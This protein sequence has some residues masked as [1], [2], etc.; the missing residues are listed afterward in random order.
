[1][2]GSVSIDGVFWERVN[3]CCDCGT[4]MVNGFFVCYRMVMKI[5]A[6]CYR[7]VATAY[8]RSDQEKAMGT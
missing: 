7:E 4:V 5:S 2:A 3:G 8:G 6:D 1:M